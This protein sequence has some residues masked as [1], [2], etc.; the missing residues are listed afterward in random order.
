MLY[1]V[2]YVFPTIKLLFSMHYVYIV[3]YVGVGSKYASF[4][5]LLTSRG[6]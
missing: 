1:N 5:N 4:I 3:S 2:S 6:W